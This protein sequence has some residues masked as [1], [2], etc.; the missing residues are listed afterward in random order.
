MASAAVNLGRHDV[1][2]AL[3]L[4][5]VSHPVWFSS[6]TRIKYSAPSLLGS[7]ALSGKNALE[8]RKALRPHLGRLLPR[9]L[10]ACHSPNKQTREQMSSLM[11]GITG[12]GADARSA[13]T[14]Y[15]TNII[16]TLI[17]DASSK[18]WRARVGACGALSEIIVGRSWRDLGGGGAI[19]DDAEVLSSNSKVTAGIRLLRLWRVAMRALDDIRVSRGKTGP[20]CLC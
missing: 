8:M 4:L 16:D 20:L 1:L 11:A 7:E 5:S 19:I 3:L 15:L 17:E 12:G 14:E 10:R 13:V 2:Y 18:L 9:I 6:E